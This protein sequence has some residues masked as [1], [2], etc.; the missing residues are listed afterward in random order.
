MVVSNSGKLDPAHRLFHCKGAPLL[1]YTTQRMPRPVREALAHTSL[2][3]LF[4][5]GTVPLRSMLADLRNTHEVRRV[6]CEGGPRLFR[7]LLEQGLVYDLCITLSAR[8]FGGAAAPSITGLPGPFLPH[9]LR[10]RLVGMEVVD[11]ECF[12]RYRLT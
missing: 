2:L 12:L 11:S 5:R 7:A 4:P 9:S 1:V 3:R 10:A 8:L 6:V